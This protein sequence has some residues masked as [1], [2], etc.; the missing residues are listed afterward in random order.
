MEIHDMSCRVDALP[1]RSC[2][3]YSILGF[4]DHCEHSLTPCVNME[5]PATEA[6]LKPVLFVP[7]SRAHCLAGSVS[8]CVGVD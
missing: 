8:C 7:A 2:S 6:Q 4:R 1:G 5:K 3:R